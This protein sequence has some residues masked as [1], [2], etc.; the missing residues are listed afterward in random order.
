MTDEFA[1]EITDDMT[2]LPTEGIE[3]S[4][5]PDGRVIY[6]PSTERVHYLNPTAV[7]VFEFCDMKRPVHQIVAF[8]QTAYQLPAPPVA[9]VHRCIASLVK[10]N[11]LRPSIPSSAA[12]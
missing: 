5:V 2:F 9:E 10:E 3:V 11:L 4:D 1:D 12:P 8:L 7:V 6:Q